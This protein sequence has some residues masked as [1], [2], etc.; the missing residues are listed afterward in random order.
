MAPTNC[1]YCFIN[2]SVYNVTAPVCVGGITAP[3]C[4]S[5]FQNG[6]NEGEIVWIGNSPVGICSECESEELSA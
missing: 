3:L 4:P 6:I 2:K 1:F 5:C